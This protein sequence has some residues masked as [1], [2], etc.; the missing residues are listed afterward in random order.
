MALVVYKHVAQ[1]IRKFENIQ[2]DF[3]ANGV[4][5]ADTITIG[6]LNGSGSNVTI[7]YTLDSQEAIDGGTAV[8][9]NSV[10]VATATDAFII[11]EYGPTG[12]KITALAAGATAWIKS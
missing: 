3:P 10:V 11:T 9:I 5:V 12:V 6:V 2:A 4:G 1:T 7:E 8:W